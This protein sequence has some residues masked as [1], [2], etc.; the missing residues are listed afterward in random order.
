MST[1]SS[2]SI[3]NQLVDIQGPGIA[4]E[5]SENMVIHI[6][7]ELVASQDDSFKVRVG[8]K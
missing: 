3:C 1:V 7:A 2:L 5:F 6:T 4:Q 8:Y